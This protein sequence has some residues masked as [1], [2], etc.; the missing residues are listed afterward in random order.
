MFVLTPTR[1]KVVGCRVGNVSS[2]VIRHDGDIIAYLVLLRPAF[3][4]SKGTA[5]CYVR[6]PGKSAVG[7]VRIEQLRIG[8]VCG[9]P[10]VQPHRVNTSIGSDADCTEIVPLVLV[11]WI[12]VNPVRSAEGYSAVGAAHEHHVC[13][14]VGTEWLH[15]GHH[16]NVIVSQSARPIHRQ[17][18]LP[19]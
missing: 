16:I 18:R 12:V 8:V 10:C 3:E 2:G 1:V 6:R 19:C 9:I 11:N 15:A 4:R 13:T 5:H 17:E 7:T 14:I